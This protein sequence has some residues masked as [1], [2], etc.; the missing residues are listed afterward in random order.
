MPPAIIVLTLI[1]G[2][3][4]G[5][6]CA[7]EDAVEPAVES[8]VEPAA[9]PAAVPVVS[10]RGVIVDNL[11]ARDRSPEQLSDFIAA[12]GKECLLQPQCAISGYSIYADGRLY[13]LDRDSSYQVEAFLKQ[14]H[15]TMEV[16]VEVS[17]KD[18]Q[19]CL[20]S[21]KNR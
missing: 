17:E 20:V 12:A 19:Y 8:A 1:A 18:D 21:I 14:P 3:L 16:E 13:E 10:L 11:D 15:S 9:G 2:L 7:Q 4:A 6:A 5:S